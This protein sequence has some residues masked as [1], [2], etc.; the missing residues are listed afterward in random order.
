MITLLN[1]GGGTLVEFGLLP[2]K[3]R[4]YADDIT[5]HLQNIRADGGEQITLWNVNHNL[6]LHM[7]FQ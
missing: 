3:E 1:N 5:D 7:T 6:I 2:A 4:Q